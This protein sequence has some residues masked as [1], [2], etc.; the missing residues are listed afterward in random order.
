MFKNMIVVTVKGTNK[1]PVFNL[2]KLKE[3]CRKAN[4]KVREYLGT[5]AFMGHGTIR[6]IPTAKRRKRNISVMRPILWR[7]L[8]IRIE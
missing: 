1:M 8:M 3:V 7:S 4:I 2:D 5:S 6:N